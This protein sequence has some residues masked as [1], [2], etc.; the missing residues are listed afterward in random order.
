MQRSAKQ[1]VSELKGINTSN[2]EVDEEQEPCS[3]AAGSSEEA[4]E[5]VK[6]L[7]QLSSVI[8]KGETQLVLRGGQLQ[9]PDAQ[10][11]EKAGAENAVAKKAAELHDGIH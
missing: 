4:A 11:G 3:I 2:V 10:E 8:D 5:L 1:L 9:D 6:K 7:P